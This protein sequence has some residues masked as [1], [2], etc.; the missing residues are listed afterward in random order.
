VDWTSPAATA[1]QVTTCGDQWLADKQVDAAAAPATGEG[2]SLQQQLAKKFP[3][4]FNTS[5]V[6]PVATHGVEH[7]I[8]TSGPP[9]ASKFRRLD[10]EKLAAA[11][12]NFDKMEAEGIIRRSTSPWFS[13]PSSGTKRG[14]HVEAMWRLLPPQPGHDAGFLP[15]PQHAGL[16]SKDVWVYSVQQ[17]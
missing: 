16:C 5:K 10:P 17:N 4:V 6:L 7:F 15:P 9:I 14:W 13:P 2:A 11:K 8:V 3:N 1:L 12:N